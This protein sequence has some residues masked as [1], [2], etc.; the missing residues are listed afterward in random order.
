MIFPYTS[1]NELMALKKM[2][3]YPLMTL[4]AFGKNEKKLSNKQTISRIFLNEDTFF[5][6]N[7]KKLGSFK[8]SDLCLI[9]PINLIGKLSQ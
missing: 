8:F 4:F 2:S 5:I 1:G 9:N 6:S 7:V 3:A